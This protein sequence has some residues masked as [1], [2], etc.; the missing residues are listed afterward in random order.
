M[1]VRSICKLAAAAPDGAAVG[2]ERA[3]GAASTAVVR[4]QGTYM[5]DFL[6][7]VGHVGQQELAILGGV[8]RLLVAAAAH[9]PHQPRLLLDDALGEDA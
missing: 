5:G 6:V 7:A 8:G 1:A 2:G 3:G 9:G 4:E